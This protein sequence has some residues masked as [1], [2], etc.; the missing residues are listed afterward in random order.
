[1]YI[2]MRSIGNLIPNGLP[3]NGFLELDEV[4]QLDFNLGFNGTGTY[5]FYGT[6]EDLWVSLWH[7]NTHIKYGKGENLEVHLGPGNYQ[8]K[9]RHAGRSGP[10][11]IQVEKS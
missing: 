1:M 10:F 3:V 2:M 8:V 4:Q 7:Y 11:S 9:I 6:P 5:R